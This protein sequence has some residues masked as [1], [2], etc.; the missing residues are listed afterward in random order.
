MNTKMKTIFK[1]L[2]VMPYEK[3]K[4]QIGK[5]EKR[6]CRGLFYIDENLS[7]INL[8]THSEDAFIIADILADDVK[9]VKLPQDQYK[10][11]AIKWEIISKALMNDISVTCLGRVYNAEW[12]NPEIN[13]I[14]GVY[15]KYDPIKRAGTYNRTNFYVKDYGI[16][17]VDCSQVEE[18]TNE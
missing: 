18:A 10:Y 6:C 16:D 2:N 8:D 17:W 15:D 5:T 3:F 13:A 11:D 1:M 12:Y 9:I 7:V 14:V 4:L